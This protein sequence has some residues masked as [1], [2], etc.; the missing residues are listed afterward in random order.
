[1]ST[2][3]IEYT[4]QDLP[5][6]FQADAFINATNIA[7]KFNKLP[8]NYLRTK[9]TKEYIEALKRSLFPVT[10]KS[11]TEQNQLVIINQ[12]GRP[13]EQGT[14]LHPKLAIDFARWLSPDFAVWC[15]MQIEKILHPV[16]NALVDLQQTEVP[17]LTYA[18]KTQREPLVKAVRKFTLTAHKKGR[19]IGFSDAHTMINMQM[20][21]DNIE[22]LTPEQIPEAI[23]I[24]GLMLKEVVMNGEY[25]PKGEAD[26]IP[27]P[28]N[29]I[30]YEKISYEQRQQIAKS[31]NDAMCGWVLGGKGTQPLHNCLRVVFSIE[32]IDDLPAK[33]FDKAIEIIEESGKKNMLFLGLMSE[34]K[35][36]FIQVY[37]R[38]NAPWT[39]DLKNKYKKLISKTFP[40]R[41]DW[42]Q[43]QNEIESKS[44][45]ESNLMV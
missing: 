39:S 44:K 13:E 25:I 4:Y 2:A 23:K 36:E 37:I 11:V 16:R 22:H 17:L 3:I 18:T 31:V 1:M 7:S 33:D 26:P 40:S 9:R 14:W 10:P 35:A 42:Q 30:V 32:R 20:G 45:S 24:V 21:V 27:E 8:E 38:Q 12:G 41:P 34:L 43:L 15:D 29:P 5:V 6:F 19:V 28:V